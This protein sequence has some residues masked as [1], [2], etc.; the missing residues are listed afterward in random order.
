MSDEQRMADH[1]WW[2]PGWKQG[3][4]FYTWHMTFDDAPDVHRI[5]EQYRQGLK[6]VAGLDLVPDRWLH[7]T[8]QGL[9]FVDE[10]SEDDVQAIVA[11]ATTRLIAIPVFELKLDRPQITPEAIRWEGAP[12]APAAA[13]R[14]AIRE[15]IGEVW[16]QVPE[17]ADG[18]APHVTIAYSNATGPTAPVAAALD[19]VDAA[20]ALAQI[21]SAELIVLGRDRRMYE[22]ETYATVPLSPIR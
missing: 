5:A 18:F 3:R 10:V 2:R 12:A 7:L 17:S 9:G 15:A 4:R 21:R 13:V 14:S 19:A 22:W 16:E 20:P 6:G 8:M 1:W 11:A